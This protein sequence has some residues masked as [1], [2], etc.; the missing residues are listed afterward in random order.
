MLKGPDRKVLS[1]WDGLCRKERVVAIGG[2]D[3]HAS[4]FKWGMLRFTPLSY[5]YLLNTINVHILLERKLSGDL[6]HAKRDIYG[7]LRE[8]RLFIAHENLAPA[9]GFRFYFISEHGSRLT[10]GQETPFEQ[11]TL[12]IEIPKQ[13][14][15]RLLKD[16]AI[17]KQ[18]RGQRAFYR[19]DEEGVYRVEVYLHL[20]LFGWRPWIFSNPIYLR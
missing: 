13:G 3:A 16:G 4:P 15:I 10:M 17:R 1:F 7:A 5:D 6:H 8:G 19:V 20:P 9:K 12:H 11:G 18:W 14:E 2:S